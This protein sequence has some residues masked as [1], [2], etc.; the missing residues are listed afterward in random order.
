MRG[1]Y[2]YDT[3]TGEIYSGLSKGNSKHEYFTWNL[4]VIFFFIG[5]IWGWM[6][7][8]ALF[9]YKMVPLL[10][11][12][13]IYISEA[14]FDEILASFGYNIG[15]L[16]FSIATFCRQQS[17]PSLN[18]ISVRTALA[19]QILIQR[20]MARNSLEQVMVLS[21]PVTKLDYT[22]QINNIIKRGVSFLQKLIPS[23]IPYN[24][25]PGPLSPDPP[26]LYKSQRES[27]TTNELIQSINSTSSTFLAANYL[28]NINTKSLISESQEISI[29]LFEIVQPIKLFRKSTQG[30]YYNIR[31]SILYKLKSICIVHYIIIG[32]I[33]IICL[34][35][36]FLGTIDVFQRR[37]RISIERNCKKNLYKLIRNIKKI[38]EFNI[39]IL[40]EKFLP[41][42]ELYKIIYDICIHEFIY[43]KEENREDMKLYDLNGHISNIAIE[44][45]K[46]IDEFINCVSIG[47]EYCTIF[48]TVDGI[49]KLDTDICRYNECIAK[50]SDIIFNQ[51][52][53]GKDDFYVISENMQNEIPLLGNP[54]EFYK[55]I[56]IVSNIIPE[57]KYL[58]WSIENISNRCFIPRSMMNSIGEL[59]PPINR[60][61]DTFLD[62]LANNDIEGLK[63]LSC[64][65]MHS[66][67][68]KKLPQFL[69]IDILRRKNGY[70]KYKIPQIHNKSSLGF[71]LPETKNTMVNYINYL[72]C[73]RVCS[74]VFGGKMSVYM[75]TS[76][77][78]EFLGN[79]IILPI[80]Y[81]SI[82]LPEV[83]EES[84]ENQMAVYYCGLSWID[85]NTVKSFVNINKNK[86]IL[87]KID[88]FYF[89][90]NNNLS[91]LFVE[92]Q[93]IWIFGFV[94]FKKIQSE[95][96]NMT[97]KI[98]N[99][100][101]QIH[102][103][104]KSEIIIL[105]ISD[106]QLFNCIGKYE[107][108]ISIFELS[109]IIRYNTSKG[110]NVFQQNTL[111]NFYYSKIEDR[112]V[113]HNNIGTCIIKGDNN[114]L[115]DIEVLN[116][117]INKITYESL[118]QKKLKN[119]DINIDNI[120]KSD[121]VNIN[122]KSYLELVD[123]TNLMIQIQ[124]EPE[125]QTNYSDLELSKNEEIELPLIW[126]NIDI[127]GLEY[128]ELTNLAKYI[129]MY[130]WNKI[131][132]NKSELNEDILKWNINTTTIE[133]FVIILDKYYHK[134]NAFHNLYHAVTVALV[135]NQWL[136]DESICLLFNSFEAYCLV[137]AALGHD[138]DHPGVNN[139]FLHKLQ[140]K[141]I[142]ENYINNILSTLE[143]Y[144][145]YSTLENHHSALLLTILNSESCNIIPPK[146]SP[147]YLIAKRIITRAIMYTDM[148]FHN[149][150][151]EAIQD[152]IGLYTHYLQ[153]DNQDSTYQ[154]ISIDIGIQL[155]NSS[156]YNQKITYDSYI[157]TKKQLYEITLLHAADISNPLLNYDIYK[158]WTVLIFEEIEQQINLEKSLGLNDKT[159]EIDLGTMQI[160]FIDAICSPF[161]TL[162]NNISPNIFKKSIQNL[163]LNRQ[164][165][166][167]TE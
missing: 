65:S 126:Q 105:D 113:N 84:L 13:D 86:I 90:M 115:Y 20:Y 82:E 18:N 131:L 14:E 140:D 94:T 29:Q 10:G 66:T 136:D 6:I 142:S 1:L 61:L 148:A 19:N 24:E 5:I 17:R 103:N 108:P 144:N 85:E 48:N 89:N 56:N 123:L 160:G 42:C 119:E 83:N 116:D 120:H 12:N 91:S 59:V 141:F 154:S 28:C 114:K 137:I 72:Y 81:N 152:F 80:C 149:I 121:L 4:Y 9:M 64:C 58:F 63:F 54:K 76:L 49:D 167:Q 37:K 107:S 92:K 104:L 165:F 55:L 157:F 161:F 15:Q 47:I 67:D 73:D 26:P 60:V 98:F 164:H 21:I 125:I 2:S 153:K 45:C 3:A 33:P 32:T 117:P 41:V 23:N 51:N 43:I 150:L 135:L 22:Q 139:E 50:I 39:N 112:L 87:E 74:F 62:N 101:N 57:S 40:K 8:Y 36:T 44:I 97:S 52:I 151:I 68:K 102:E 46:I 35:V 71:S 128:K 88:F 162:M 25:Q 122:D 7:I 110:N 155:P 134:K 124:H 96:P 100:Y 69:I 79:T 38:D 118:T 147:Y 70:N 111:S 129:L 156:F 16:G 163:E 138:I 159:G 133:N 109:E 95:Y 53:R 78:S 106:T 31:R 34:L 130:R 93:G 11:S 99:K 132:D 127:L 166:L 143:I 146:N 75:N 158:K 77:D 27:I 30:E 145:G